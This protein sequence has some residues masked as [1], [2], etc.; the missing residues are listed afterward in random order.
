MP[1]CIPTVALILALLQ[2]T[3]PPQ[4]AGDPQAV[5]APPR[6]APAAPVPA[7]PRRG[8]RMMVAGFATF[9]AAYTAFILLGAREIARSHAFAGIVDERGQR[10]GSRELI[11][12]VGPLTLLT[13]SNEPG[14]PLYAVLG[15]LAQVTGLGLGIAGAVL[16]TR[17]RLRTTA[18][19]RGLRP[20]RDLRLGAAPR[21]G[22]GTLDLTYRF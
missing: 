4:P 18:A 12:V 3:A 11:P 10:Q 9:G 13:T 1:H 8:Q 6:P 20:T 21:R 19:G 15:F 22:G 17:T 16:H 7:P 2:D 14:A 5:A